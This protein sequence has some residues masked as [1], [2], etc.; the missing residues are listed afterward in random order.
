MFPVTPHQITTNRLLVVGGGP[1]G[2]VAANRLTEDPDI[3][4]LVIEAGPADNRSSSF[5]SPRLAGEHIGTLID[6][7]YTTSAQKH[8]DGKNRFIPQGHLLGGSSV[9]GAMLWE[10]PGK[11][12]IDDWVRLGNP[13]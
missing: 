2:L 12:D 9:L 4:V 1:A 13:G 11:D 3:N 8:L 10:T 5:T 6:W 7:N